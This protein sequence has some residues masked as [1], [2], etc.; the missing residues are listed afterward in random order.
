M[1]PPS[2]SA[3]F[4]FHTLAGLP[5]SLIS[6]VETALIAL[7]H[8]FHL[9]VKGAKDYFFLS[10]IVALVKSR[11]WPAQSI[12][13]KQQ[14]VERVLSFTQSLFSRHATCEHLGAPGMGSFKDNQ[15]ATFVATPGMT[16]MLPTDFDGILPPPNLGVTVSLSTLFFSCL[17][18]DA[19]YL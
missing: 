6:L 8:R 3:T 1:H 4:T 2:T 7:E 15:V 13:Y 11:V 10:T 14:V 16:T 5:D 19:N 18:V 12:M 17:F 9:V